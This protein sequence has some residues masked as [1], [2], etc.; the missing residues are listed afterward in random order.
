LEEISSSSGWCIKSINFR[1]ILSWLW[2][3]KN[4]HKGSCEFIR[5]LQYF[6]CSP[7]EPHVLHPVRCHCY[8][9]SL[10]GF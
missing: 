10:W 6:I 2:H 1:H 8:S 5:S 7:P 9:H 3:P 4:R